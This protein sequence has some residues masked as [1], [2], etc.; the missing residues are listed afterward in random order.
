V[1]GYGAVVPKIAPFEETTAIWYT[2]TNYDDP[3]DAVEGAAEQAEA[4]SQAGYVLTG[5]GMEPVSFDPE[6]KTGVFKGYITFAGDAPSGS[7]PVMGIVEK[8]P[9]WH[10]GLAAGGGIIGGVI[11]GAII[12]YAAR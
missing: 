5:V 11:I 6:T 8:P 2:P 3:E 12:G 7:Q 1:S 10:Y 9:W 4:F